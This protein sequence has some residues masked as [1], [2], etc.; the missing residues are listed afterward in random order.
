VKKI[1][2][3]LV[4]ATPLSSQVYA[5]DVNNPL[6]AALASIPDDLMQQPPEYSCSDPADKYSCQQVRTKITFAPFNGVYTNHEFDMFATTCFQPGIEIK[7]R[8]CKSGGDLWGETMINYIWTRAP[9][10]PDARCVR[11]GDPLSEPY[12]ACVA[13]LPPLPGA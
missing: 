9:E 1:L 11:W 2:L 5:A 10:T 6:V 3:A 7:Y 13:G 8:L 4:L 12:L